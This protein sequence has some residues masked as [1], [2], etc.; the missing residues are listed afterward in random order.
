MPVEVQGGGGAAGPGGADIGCRVTKS[1]SQSIPNGAFT[2]ITWN[3]EDYDTDGM[4]DNAVNN[5]RITIQTA[6]KY[7]VFVGMDWAASNVGRRLHS[8]YL[9]GVEVV[10]QRRIAE[11]SS[12]DF[13]ATMLIPLIVTDFI[14]LFVNQNSGGALNFDPGFAFF[15][16]QKIDRGG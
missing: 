11:S 4:H 9:N 15:G 10:R 13:S 2:A 3:Q 12:E 8:I 16:A 6:G 14:E 5:S 1:A 7:F